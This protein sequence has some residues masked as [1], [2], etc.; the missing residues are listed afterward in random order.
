MRAKDSKILFV[1]LN[2]MDNKDLLNKNMVNIYL[3]AKGTSNFFEKMEQM[4]MES[5]ANDRKAVGLDLLNSTQHSEMIDSDRIFSDY[6]KSIQPQI[7]IEEAQMMVGESYKGVQEQIRVQNTQHSCLRDV[8]GQEKT[9]QAHWTR[10]A[11]LL[12]IDKQNRQQVRPQGCSRVHDGCA[13][14][15]VY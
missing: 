14:E 8:L 15:L 7:E 2:Q 3:I 11:L 4:S 12:S 13:I 5:V 1:Y 6:I 10:Q 9:K